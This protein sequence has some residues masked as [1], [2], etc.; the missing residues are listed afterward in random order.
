MKLKTL[1]KLN[2]NQK[3]NYWKLKKIKTINKL[4][5]KN[6][7]PNIKQKLTNYRNK[8]KRKKKFRI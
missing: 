3:I 4:T 7:N 2:K 1:I 6:Y 8:F 5:S